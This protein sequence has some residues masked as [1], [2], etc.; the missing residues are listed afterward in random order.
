MGKVKKYGILGFIC[1]LGLSIASTAGAGLLIHL[2]DGRILKVNVSKE[3]FMG[4]SFEKGEDD[5]LQ[6]LSW[7]FETGGLTGWT[8]T[9][10]A[11]KNQPT[12]GD[13]PTARNR[14]QASNHQGQYWIGTYENRH[15]SSDPAGA[16]QG[17]AP[18]GTLTST[19]FI[20]RNSRISFLVGG[21]L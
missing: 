3:D 20:L 5:S 7:D 8:Q 17:D 11:F 12:F 18:Q 4:L 10:E 1:V 16:V 19:P 14:G 2:K 13:N 9:G 6:N 15:Q 21:G